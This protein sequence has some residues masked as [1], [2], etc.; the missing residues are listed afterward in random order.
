[1]VTNNGFDINFLIRLTYWFKWGN[2][3]WLN[4]LKYLHWNS[5]VNIGFWY[6]LNFILHFYYKNWIDRRNFKLSLFG[7]H[8]LLWLWDYFT[9]GLTAV[10]EQKF[11]FFFFKCFLKINFIGQYIAHSFEIIISTGLH[12]LRF[13]LI[14]S[15]IW[16]KLLYR[17]TLQ[18]VAIT[19]MWVDGL[20]LTT[21]QFPINGGKKLSL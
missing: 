17:K 7:L 1:M 19:G 5:F 11:G 21:G 14:S 6:F 15:P 8:W 13:S 9:Y 10:K 3:C 4:H 12:W 16:S 18:M 20:L 2:F